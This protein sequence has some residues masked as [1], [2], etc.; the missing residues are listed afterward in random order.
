LFSEVRQNAVDAQLHFMD[1]EVIDHAEPS[2]TG[3]VR[4][5]ALGRVVVVEDS[6]IIA[7]VSGL[8]ADI[9]NLVTVAYATTQDEAL[10]IPPRG[11]GSCH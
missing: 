8:L 1:A 6:R 4:P 9:P 10:A 11:M 5:R 2:P 3:A 7:N